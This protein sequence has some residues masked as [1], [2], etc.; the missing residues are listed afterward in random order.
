M[1]TL[2]TPQHISLDS[3]KLTLSAPRSWAELTHEQWRYVLTMLTQRLSLEVKILMLLRFCGIHVKGK[4]SDGLFRC[5][6][7][8]GNK[9]RKVDLTAWQVQQALHTFDYIDS[10]D[11]YTVRLDSVGELHAVDSLLHE[12]PFSAYLAM[13]KYY[14]GFLR[15]RNNTELLEKLGQLLYVT[16]DGKYEDK[17]KFSEVE[18]LHCFLWYSYVKKQFARYFPNFFRPVSAALDKGT[19]LAILDQMNVQIRALTGGDVTKEEAVM[20]MD[21]WRALTELDAKAREAAEIK[22]M[23]KK[24]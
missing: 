1:K 23:N 5:L 20:K 2:R 3:G 12:V 6:V 7:P 16:R 9:Q 15:N 17:Q 19:E 22:K 18:R 13:E 14:Q 21:C 10:Y 11:E 24:K 4:R 8:E